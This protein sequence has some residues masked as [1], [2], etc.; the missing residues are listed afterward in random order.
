MECL[1]VPDSRGTWLIKSLTDL[2]KLV[3][4]VEGGAGGAQTQ[5]QI[6]VKCTRKVDQR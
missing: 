1:Y 5:K 3:I 6:T 2:I 4:G